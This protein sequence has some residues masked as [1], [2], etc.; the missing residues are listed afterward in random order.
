MLTDEGS[1]RLNWNNAMH[2]YLHKGGAMWVKNL[3]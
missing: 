3:I 2:L 1:N